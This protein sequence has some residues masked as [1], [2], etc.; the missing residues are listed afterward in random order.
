MSHPDYEGVPELAMYSD[1]ELTAQIE[2]LLVEAIVS[3]KEELTSLD[4]QRHLRPAK[5]ATG[6]GVSIEHDDVT[7][8]TE[9]NETIV[10]RDGV[11]YGDFDVVTTEELQDP[12]QESTEAL[13]R[14]AKR[15]DHKAE[16]GLVDPELERIQLEEIYVDLVT[17][18]DVTD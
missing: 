16:M 10:F 6:I 15:M 14:E 8:G 13:R 3:G 1:R 9:T 7:D 5:L 17:G 11:A 4:G 2:M 18:I 12:D